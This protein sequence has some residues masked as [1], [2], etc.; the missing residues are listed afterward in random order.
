MREASSLHTKP[1]ELEQ[2]W[3]ALRCQIMDVVSYD[4]TR[5]VVISFLYIPA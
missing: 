5:I 1:D 3:V 2:Y 4:S